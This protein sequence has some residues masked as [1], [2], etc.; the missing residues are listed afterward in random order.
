M[1]KRERGGPVMSPVMAI[2]K[3]SGLGVIVV[4]QTNSW[5]PEFLS[6]WRLPEGTAIV[7]AIVALLSAASANAQNQ[8]AP[9]PGA[10]EE[11]VV[12]AQKREQNSQDVGLSLTVF[13]ASDL[14]DLGVT[15]AQDLAKQT[16]GLSFNQNAN[17]D[18]SMTFSLRGVGLN[19][20]SGFNESPVAMYFDGVYQAT[21]AGNNSQLFDIERVEVLKGPQ[22]TLFGRNTTGGL[23]QFISRKPTDQPEAY[24]DVTVGEFNLRRYEGAV[25]GPVNNWLKVRVSAVSLE[26]DGYVKEHFPNI[27][28]AGSGNEYGLRLQLEATPTERTDVLVSTYYTDA[29]FI[30]TPYK[31]SSVFLGPDGHT[32]EFLPGNEVN[33]LCPGKPGADCL[34]YV[35]RDPNPWSIDNNRQG[36]SD[37]Q[38][39]GAAVTIDQTFERFKFTSITAFQNVNKLYQEDSDAGPVPGIQVDDLVNSQQWS[40]ELRLT[41]GSDPLRW[42]SG[43][44]YFGRVVRSGPKVD[45]TGV[46]FITGQ[47]FVH[48]DTQSYAAF[49]Q[50][51]YDLTPHWTAIAGLRYT[52]ERRVFDLIADDESGLAV[53]FGFPPNPIIDFSP[54]TVGDLAVHDNGS[55]SARAELEWRPTD[56]V[57]L[58]SS[59]ARGVKGAGFNQDPGLNGPRDPNTIPVG[60]EVL[61]AYE[62][63]IKSTEWTGK[64]R[65][66]AAVFYYDYKGFQAF[67]FENLLNELSNKNAQIYGFE[68]DIQAHPTEGWYFRLGLE[69][70]HS[71]LEGLTA[72]DDFTKE[73]VPLG[74]RQM[75]LAPHVQANG[76]AR[77]QWPLGNGHLGL[78]ADV[79]YVG[80]QYLQIDNNPTSFQPA[81]AVIDGRLAYATSD[82][83]YSIALWEKNIADKE[84]RTFNGPIASNGY[85]L[86]QF[87]RPRWVGVTF[88]VNF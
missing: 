11:V 77:Y 69:L 3:R 27:A 63:G 49:G 20:F 39:F 30:P 28:D 4:I 17:D 56:L 81:Y 5:A 45:L 8:R 62:L 7:A 52:H 80:S 61:N 85:T 26:N 40:Q 47:A 73:T 29:K 79:S 2:T 66:N 37:L 53:S 50:L 78:Q 55:V 60:Q 75:A 51:E 57:M 19:D 43:L 33:P 13:S 74:D 59:W 36:L 18:V 88:R 25:S 84:Y 71:N 70:L 48:D 32:V 12:T 38:K 46:G 76:Q 14:R 87:G 44:Y 35:D 72:E 9:E 86:Q 16:P 21:L 24:A 82:D 65:A 64:L 1:L 54:A 67:T 83:R 41:G 23:V 42:T 68:A 58:Y 34:G 22:G 6:R 31:H 10:L 15:S